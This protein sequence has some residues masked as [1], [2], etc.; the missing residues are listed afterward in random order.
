MCPGG[1][2]GGTS[3]WRPQ[4]KRGAEALSITGF[5]SGWRPQHKRGRIITKEMEAYEGI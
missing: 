1:E 4:H 2:E 5:S 3:G